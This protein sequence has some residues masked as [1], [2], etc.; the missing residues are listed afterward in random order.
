MRA[1]DLSSCDELDV[2]INPEEDQRPLLL[3]HDLMDI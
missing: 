2:C 3:P 1:S